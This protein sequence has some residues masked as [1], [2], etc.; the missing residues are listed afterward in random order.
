MPT[1]VEK[2]LAFD[3]PADWEITKYDR[4]ADLKSGEPASFYRRVIEKGGVQNVQ[5][6]DVVC[7][8]PNA[9]EHLQFIEIKDERKRMLSAAKRHNELYKIVLSKT[10]GT[11]AGLLL[12]ERLQEISLYSQAC[13]TR[14][15]VVEVVLFLV[16][17]LS[18]IISA[19]KNNFRRL[20]K[21]DQVT[22][23]DQ[24]LNAKLGQWNLAFRLYNL[25]DR[26]APDWQVRDLA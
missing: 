5:G 3:F 8:L 16:E 12:A 26:L 22:L 10:V 17:P 2:K 7:R 18:A 6:M 1:V 20:N 14:N 9:A 4:Q 23:L 25:T 13:L 24:R 21:Q 11:L 15:P 19:D